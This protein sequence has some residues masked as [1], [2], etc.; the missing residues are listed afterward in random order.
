MTKFTLDW[1]ATDVDGVNRVLSSGQT[2]QFTVSTSADGVASDWSITTCDGQAWLAGRAGAGPLEVNIAFADPVADLAFELLDLDADRS[3][4]PVAWQDAIAVIGQDD[5]GHQVPVGLSDPRRQDVASVPGTDHHPLNRVAITTS[6]PVTLLTVRIESSDASHFIGIGQISFE[7][8]SAFGFDDEDEDD[9]FDILSLLGAD[10][11]VISYDTAD[12]GAGRVTFLD[13]NTMLFSQI[14]HI[15]PCFTPG[16]AIATPKGEIAVEKLKVGDR[17]LTRDNGI[18]RINWIGTKRIDFDQLK[19]TPQFR[20]ILI[21]QGAIGDGLPER[22]ML[23]SPSHRML[24]V[25]EFAQLYFGQSEVLVAAKHM[26]AM[27]G[28]EISN[29]PYV[30]YVHFMCDNHEIVLSDGTWSE[31]YQPGDFTLKGFDNDQREELF[32]LFPELATKE[33]IAAYGAA[34]RTLSKREAK[35][36]FKG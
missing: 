4:D 24:I 18:Q 21:K 34:R 15:I 29:Q 32:A 25:S 9:D 23:V 17:V 2:A 16:T 1:S 33:G 26:L 7:T 10:V 36:L 5:A 11:D 28:V 8:D 3:G 13:G 14:E 12:P 27:D 20:P 31:S 19:S 22:D 35:L 6:G 30:T